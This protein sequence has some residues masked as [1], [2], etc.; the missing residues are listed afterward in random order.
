LSLHGKIELTILDYCV[1]LKDFFLDSQGHIMARNLYIDES[2]VPILPLGFYLFSVKF[3]ENFPQQ[4]SELVG[5]AKYYCEAKEMVERKPKPKVT[6][7]FKAI[8]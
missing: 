5:V 1:V 4:P 7:L 3:T 6:C 8:N 2:T